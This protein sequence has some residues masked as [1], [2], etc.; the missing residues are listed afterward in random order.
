MFPLKMYLQFHELT[1][2]T[3]RVFSIKND[4]S[5]VVCLEK[6]EP[7]GIFGALVKIVLL[8]VDFGR[9]ECN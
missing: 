5:H 1:S 8:A 9:L 7:L 4:C 3:S 2:F 6:R